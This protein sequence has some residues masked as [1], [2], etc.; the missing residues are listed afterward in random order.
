MEISVSYGYRLKISPSATTAACLLSMD[1]FPK[2]Y[3]RLNNN[4]RKEIIFINHDSYSTYTSAC[5]IYSIKK[6]DY[7]YLL[8]NFM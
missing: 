1:N 5:F 4:S 7:C 8:T 3:W 2:K 6:N